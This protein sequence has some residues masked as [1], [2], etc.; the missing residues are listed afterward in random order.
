M[1]SPGWPGLCVNAA[2]G[3]LR[4]L[5]FAAAILVQ[6]APVHAAGSF[7]LPDP[8]GVT[9]FTLGVAGL[10]IGRKFAGKRKD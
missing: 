9:L 10:L 6:A 3:R 2:V 7:A 5:L 8:S 1:L 4:N